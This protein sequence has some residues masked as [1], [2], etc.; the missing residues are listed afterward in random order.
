MYKGFWKRFCDIVISSFALL[1]LWPLFIII[2]L[3]IKLDD[4]GP[5]FYKQKRTGKNGKIFHMYKFRSMNVLPEGKEMTV[6]HEKRVT[7][8][9]AFLRKTSLDE[10]AQFINVFKGEM[11]F[12][13]PRPWMTEYYDNFTEKQKQRV[14]VKPGIIGLAQAKGRNGLTI[15][16]KINYDIEYVNKL[17]FLL[18]FKIFF[19]SIK[20]ILKR[21]HAE[22]TQEDIKTELKILKNQF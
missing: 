21:E 14:K 8:V 20:I 3:A 17:S 22:I 15:F 11:S 18:D 13:G 10:L 6:S 7:K 5:V 16:E 4:R 19:E 9:G 2:G 12:I 1:I